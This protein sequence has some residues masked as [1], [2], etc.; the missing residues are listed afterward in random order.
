MSKIHWTVALLSRIWRDLS[1]PVKSVFKYIGN[2]VKWHGIVRFNRTV[3][4]GVGSTL[5]GANSLGDRTRFSGH[6]G[7]GSYTGQNCYL[8]AN[9]GRFTSISD[10]VVNTLGTHPYQAPF[11]TTSPMFYS[12]L[13][14][15]ME[16]FASYQMFNEILDP[17]QIGNDCWIGAR[18][19][20]AGGLTIGDGAVVLTGAVVVN[21]VPPYAIVGGVPAK[22]IKYRYDEETIAWLQK[23]KW[24]NKPIEWLRENSNLLCD[25]EKLKEALDEN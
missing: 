18:V 7:Y 20:F 19:Y 1:S 17:V 23:T 3:S 5:E 11:A 16:T 24:W 2:K 13:K 10:E 6:M 4:I 14:Q 21:N 8:R 25:I 22:I 12:M 9:I 15:S